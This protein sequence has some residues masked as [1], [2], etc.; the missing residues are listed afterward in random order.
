MT[1]VSCTEG[2]HNIAVCI[3]SELLGE[4]LLATLHLFLGLVKL[5]S[6][7]LNAYWLT[8]FLGIETQVLKQQG[9][10]WLQGC[11][12]SV[13]IGAVSGKLNLYAQVVAHILNNLRK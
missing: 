10:S 1:T 8:L 7:L 2:I 11:Y 9:L 12:L 5:G 3:R 13:G 4:V 6:T